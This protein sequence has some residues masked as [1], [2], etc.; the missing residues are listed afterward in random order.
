MSE[1]TALDVSEAKIA[2]LGDQLLNK[3]GS[4]PLHTRFRALFTLKSLCNPSPASNRSANI[5]EIIG[6]GLTA[7]TTSALLRHEL[8]YVLGQIGSTHAVPV[9]ER[10]LE[11]IEGQE[12]MVRH[13]AAEALAAIGNLSD[14]T[15]EL[16]QRF[17]KAGG[18]GGTDDGRVVR[19]TCEIALAK[20]AWNQSQEAKESQ[21]SGELL[22]RCV[23]IPHSKFNDFHV[24]H[25]QESNAKQSFSCFFPTSQFTSVDPAP[26]L[27][28]HSP[29]AAQPNPKAKVSSP[30]TITNVRALRAALLD[31]HLQ[32][33]TRYRA[34]FALRNIGTPEAIDALCAGFDD[35]SALF[36]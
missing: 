6:S 11:D 8:A 12:E 27:I 4:M 13:E 10:T 29:L 35:D 30:S 32:L 20:I 7:P 34:M 14:E 19:E 22:D 24:C 36:K 28:A 17:A 5:I 21:E 31:T 1:A 9:L 15:I 3:S 25:L 16:L 33:F 2:E 18:R 23:Q 26:P